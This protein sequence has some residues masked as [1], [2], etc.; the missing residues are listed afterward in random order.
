MS[1]FLKV[2]K[3]IRKELLSEQENEQ[4][5]EIEKEPIEGIDQEKENLLN[6]QTSEI[7]NI[8]EDSINV[9]WIKKII[10]LLTLLNRQDANVDRI[11]SDLSDGE[12]NADTLKKKESLI[13]ELISSIPIEKNS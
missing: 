6:N 3:Y 5:P 13:D 12:V 4:L 10:K 9:N 1:Q 2:Y 11:L 8:E 7:K